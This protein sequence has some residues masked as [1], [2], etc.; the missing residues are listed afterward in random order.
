[1]SQ[2][3]DKQIPS[4]DLNDKDAL[5]ARAGEYHAQGDKDAMVIWL[6]KAVA[7]GHI[8]AKTNLGLCYFFGDNVEQDYE[9]AFE[10][11]KA[12][13]SADDQTAKYYLALCYLDGTGVEQDEDYG[14]RVLWK[15]AS[16]GMSWAQLSLAECY[17]TGRV[18]KED[19]F[20][21]ISW[22]ARAAESDIPEAQEKFRA[23]YYDNNFEDAEGNQRYFWF[24][25]ENMDA[26]GDPITL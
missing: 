23:L 9:Q 18:V 2:D 3:F 16:D 4:T 14:M 5:F 12:A 24:E 13:A 8:K 17:E 20:E 11:L 19:L 25:E 6:E 1:M 21:A 15:C 26:D 7:K 22:Y 10:L